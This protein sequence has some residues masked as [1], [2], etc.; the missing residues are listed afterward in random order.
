MFFYLWFSFPQSP[1]SPFSIT[2]KSLTWVTLAS[3][4][5]ILL[6]QASLKTESAGVFLQSRMLTLPTNQN[7]GSKVGLAKSTLRGIQDLFV[8]DPNDMWFQSQ[9]LNLT[10]G[11]L[12]AWSSSNHILRL[13]VTSNSTEIFFLSF[14]G[15]ICSTWKFSGYGSNWSCSCRPTPQPQQHLV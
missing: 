5:F 1:S 4:I 13:S 15:C 8:R 11:D 6:A 2:E 9:I 12:S 14:Y 3:L 7:V 10:I